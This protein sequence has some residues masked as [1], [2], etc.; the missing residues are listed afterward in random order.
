MMQNRTR[1]VSLF[2]CLVLL[3]GCNLPDD[4]GGEQ[5]ADE[6]ATLVAKTLAALTPLNPGD[7][8]APGQ[9]SLTPEPSLTPSLTPTWTLAVT[10]TPK[11]GAIA[12]GV[13]GY[14]Y[15]SL[16][17]LT[18]V[19]FNQDSSAYWWWINGAGLS[20]FGTDP[21][22]PPGRY[23]VVVYDSAGH[24]GACAGIVT[25]AADQTVTCDVTSWGGSYPSRPGGVPLP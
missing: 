10:A 14:P 23:Q 12:G 3:A 25:V 20:Y 5:T 18:F 19:A 7:T 15:G 2:L 8:P 6:V 11:P 24:S 4:M 22:I 1:L 21:F 9:P 16:P 13:Y 17:G